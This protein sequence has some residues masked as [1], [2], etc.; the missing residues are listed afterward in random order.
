MFEKISKQSSTHL[1]AL[2]KFVQMTDGPVMELGSGV[3]S[4]PVLHW[5]CLEKNRKLVTYENHP[6]FFQFAKKFKSRDHQI[7][8]IKDWDQIDPRGHWS[9]VLIDHVSE[10]GR[11][12]DA[13]KFKDNADYIILHDSNHPELYGYNEI[14]KY[15]KYR[16]DYIRRD[17]S[18]T[19]LSNFK[20][21]SNLNI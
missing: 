6:E 14:W 3:F 10:R 17:A 19:V 18:T 5:M 2:V 4:T 21:L 9:V 11:G 13:V 20:D 16:H 12:I 15:F 8:F 7:L 1:Q